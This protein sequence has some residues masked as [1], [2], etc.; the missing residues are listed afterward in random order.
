MSPNREL[1]PP[2]GH[3]LTA[4]S[5][6]HLDVYKR[7]RQYRVRLLRRIATDVFRTGRRA[8]AEVGAVA[9]ATPDTALDSA[10]PAPVL[11]V[12]N[13]SPS[14]RLLRDQW[15]DRC[16]GRCVHEQFGKLCRPAQERGMRRIDRQRFNAKTC[17]NDIGEP[18]RL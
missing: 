8:G 14:V 13:G 18:P 17:G 2:A 3:S 6:T 1:Q 4:V 10:D 9:V 12:M 11:V 5:Y 16:S 15:S 7:Q